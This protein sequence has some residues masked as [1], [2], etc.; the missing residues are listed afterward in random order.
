MKYY[1]IIVFSFLVFLNS[2]NSWFNKHLIENYYIVEADVK[3]DRDVS[4]QI[5]SDGYLGLTGGQVVEVGVFN[6]YLVAKRNKYG[7]NYSAWDTSYFIIPIYR[8]KVL[9]P[10]LGVLGPLDYD[11]LIR[12]LE[13]KGMNLKQFEIIYSEK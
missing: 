11:Q 6:R 7:S 10:S 2:C 1:K 4:Y 3:E 8:E 5:D 12:E 13:R 9:D